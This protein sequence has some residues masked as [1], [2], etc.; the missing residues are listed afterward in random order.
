[1]W[2]PVHNHVGVAKSSEQL[3][4]TS[5][6]NLVNGNT[7]KPTHGAIGKGNLNLGRR[8]IAQMAILPTPSLQKTQLKKGT[9]K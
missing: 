9:M 6:A 5:G 8:T 3:E 7:I 4:A 2:M 1:M